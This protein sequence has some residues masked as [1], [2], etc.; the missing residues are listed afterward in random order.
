MNEI[1]LII[2]GS[3]LALV[4]SFSVELYKQ[5]NMTKE[6]RHDA[7]IFLTLELKNVISL[8]EKLNDS[9]ASNRFFLIS[10][11]NQ[12]SYSM[13]RLERNRNKVMCLKHSQ[14]K[15]EVLSCFNELSTLY[16]DILQNEN[17][18]FP[19]TPSQV[20]PGSV[21]KNWDDSYFMTKRQIF[22]SNLIELKR[23]LQDI[24]SN[25]EI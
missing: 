14:K 9:F 21:V 15:E 8:I 10:L 7:T 6:K 5:F 18:A 13:G 1:F 4:S 22:S 24:I 2:L 20:A 3:F 12:L 25:P 23:R 19:T 17:S 16:S 11:L